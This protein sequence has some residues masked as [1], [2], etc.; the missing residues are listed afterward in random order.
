MTLN[1]VRVYQTIL[2]NHPHDSRG[3]LSYLRGS[4]GGYGYLSHATI[5]GALL[6]RV[7]RE[8]K[9]NRIRLRCLVPKEE[10]P[11]GGL[12]VYGA[13]CGRYPIGPTLIVE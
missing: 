10:Q 9:A 12:T 13:E 5:E 11:H 4:R 1:G 3:A 8:T 6:E 7:K 2:P